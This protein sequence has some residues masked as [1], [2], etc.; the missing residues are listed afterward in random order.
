MLKTSTELEIIECLP[1]VV[2]TYIIRHNGTMDFTYVSPACKRILGLPADEILLG[3]REIEEYV[4]PEDWP[5]FE[6]AR[7]AVKKSLC[8]FNWEGRLRMD[9][10][11]LWISVTGKPRVTDKKDILIFGVITAFFM[12]KF[13]PFIS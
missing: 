1:V 9:K 11:D 4:H 12:G 7:E 13:Y 10:K 5:A 6:A 8:D 2:F 3:N